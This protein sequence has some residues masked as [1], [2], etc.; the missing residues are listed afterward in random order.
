MIGIRLQIW[1]I[2][3]F[4][5]CVAEQSSAEVLDATPNG[6][7]IRHQVTVD[8]DRAVVYGAFVDL[9]GQWWSSDLT[10]S[11]NAANLYL[12]ATVP[13]CFCEAFGEHSG[14]V[15]MM[16]TFVNPG[17]MLRLT[18]GLGPLGLMGVAGNMTLEFDE[19]DSGTVVTMQY[20]VGGYMDGGLDMVAPT[21]DGVLGEAM[22]RLT[23]YVETGSPTEG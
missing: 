10:F 1:L 22:T 8:A 7:T 3:F 4:F 15:H 18:G 11:G 6:F 12:T 14:L 23:T 21:V 16:V 20:A 5:L 19:S 9:I 17:V 13:G 2:V